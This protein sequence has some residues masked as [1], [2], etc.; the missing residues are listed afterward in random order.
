ME[1]WGAEMYIEIEIENNNNQ[2]WIRT[3]MINRVSR[4]IT[5]LITSTNLSRMSTSSPASLTLDVI[6]NM[7]LAEINLRYRPWQTVPQLESAGIVPTWL[8]E[9]ID[10]AEVEKDWT[11]LLDLS[12]V[13]LL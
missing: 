5:Q 7:P 2:V 1:K 4:P 3:R 6:Q 11:G 9:P 8:T 10:V 13:D 12:T